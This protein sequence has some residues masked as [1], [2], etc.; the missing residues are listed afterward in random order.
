[1]KVQHLC[2][3][4]HNLCEELQYNLYFPSSKDPQKHV[5]KY[6]QSLIEPALKATQYHFYNVI[7][8][9]QSEAENIEEMED[10]PV[11]SDRPCS[12]LCMKVFQMDTLKFT[13]E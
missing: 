9:D 6:P 11:I 12:I 5:G 1:M 10:A 3:V 8:K 13:Y 4:K 2:Q 7:G